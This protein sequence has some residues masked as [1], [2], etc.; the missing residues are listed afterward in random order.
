MDEASLLDEHGQPRGAVQHT[1]F[2]RAIRGRLLS[3]MRPTWSA[4]YG[5]TCPRRS[6]SVSA[7]R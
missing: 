7:Q 4:C 2:A 1:Q 6:I 5:R 3:I